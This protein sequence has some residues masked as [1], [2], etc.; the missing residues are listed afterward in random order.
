MFLI[1]KLS[2]FKNVFSLKLLKAFVN[3]LSLENISKGIQK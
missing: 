2:F 1:H 3:E